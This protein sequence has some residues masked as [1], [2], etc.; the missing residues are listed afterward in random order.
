MCLFSFELSY[1]VIWRLAGGLVEELMSFY[2]RSAV[3]V[4]LWIDHKVQLWRA[5]SAAATAA[6]ACLVFHASQF[7]K[8]PKLLA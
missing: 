2:T 7:C 5:L 4:P 1:E 6:A 3:V 8:K